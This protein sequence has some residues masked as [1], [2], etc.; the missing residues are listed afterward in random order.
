MNRFCFCLEKKDTAEK[1]KQTKTQGTQAFMDFVQEVFKA[2]G[3][4]SEAGQGTSGG[5]RARKDKN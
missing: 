2:A 1:N 4:S 3:L 5:V